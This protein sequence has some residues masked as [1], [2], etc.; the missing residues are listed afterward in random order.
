M[1]RTSIAPAAL[2]QTAAAYPP[3]NFA[4]LLKQ[5]G[6]ARGRLSSGTSDFCFLAAY[7]F[8][9][10]F[11]SFLSEHEQLWRK[12]ALR[13]TK[14]SGYL[15]N[16]NTGAQM[17]FLILSAGRDAD[18]LK[19]RNAALTEQGYKVA[20]A[21]NSCEAVDKLLN[22]DFDLVLLCHTMPE[23]DRQRLARIIAS[24]SPST[25]VV[26]ISETQRSDCQM[27]PRV[28]SCRPDQLLHT[29]AHSLPRPINPQAA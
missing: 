20:A 26:I 12:L 2:L 14:H 1:G 28:L 5:P 4:G 18:L 29:L 17:P 19:R 10:R 25:P 21:S 9:I 15:R 23:D 3:V 22:G 27:G 7:R 24:Y 13:G 11:S 6:S 16:N 8:L